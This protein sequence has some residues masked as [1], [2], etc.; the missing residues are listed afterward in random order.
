[1]PALGSALSLLSLLC[2][3][4]CLLLAHLTRELLGLL[5]QFRL[6]TREPLEP[7]SHFFGA[8][9]I[10]LLCE[11]FLLPGELFLPPRELADAILRSCSSGRDP[12]LRQRAELLSRRRM[13]ER[14]I[15][16]YESVV[17]GAAA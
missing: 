15:A 17:A 10:A 3:L 13:A 6:L 12:I 8:Q 4:P 11:V 9:P 5:P 14:T 1:M 2:L 7:A 16:L